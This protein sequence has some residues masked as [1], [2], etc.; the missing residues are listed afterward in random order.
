MA[1][2]VS[3]KRSTPRTAGQAVTLPPIILEAATAAR[4]EEMQTDMGAK[5]GCGRVPKSAVISLLIRQRDPNAPYLDI[6]REV[7]VLRHTVLR[8]LDIAR[9][10]I[11]ALL[12]QVPA[13]P[14]P[15]AAPS[16]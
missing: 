14:A 9:M 16:T 2:K 6:L 7:R 10:Q 11:S 3:K 13:A 5:L 15:K 8:P 4:L 1:K 12:R